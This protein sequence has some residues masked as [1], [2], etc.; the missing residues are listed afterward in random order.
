MPSSFLNQLQI[1]AIICNMQKQ[2]GI[3]PRLFYPFA[4]SVAYST[5]LGAVYTLPAYSWSRAYRPL[6]SEPKSL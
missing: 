1:P 4:S 6:G 2:A 3:S 5:R